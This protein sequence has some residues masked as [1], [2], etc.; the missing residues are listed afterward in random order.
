MSWTSSLFYMVGGGVQTT[1]LLLKIT[2][3]WFE[4]GIRQEDVL[5]P[6]ESLSVRV[7][8][9]RFETY[10]NKFNSPIKLQY[11]L[12]V[13]PSGSVLNPEKTLVLWISSFPG[14]TF[15]R[16]ERVQGERTHLGCPSPITLYA[17]YQNI[18]VVTTLDLLVLRFLLLCLVFSFLET[19][20]RKEGDQKKE[21]EQ[22]APCIRCVVCDTRKLLGTV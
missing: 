7:M 1:Y 11:S 14:K 12:I 18:K 10:Y 6:E 5:Y 19:M 22:D 3:I 9:R 21:P 2:T 20:K 8:Y 4:T 16:V 13:L 15:L 17:T